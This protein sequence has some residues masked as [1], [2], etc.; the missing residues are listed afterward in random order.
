MMHHRE[1]KK[2]GIPLNMA[3]VPIKAAL[4]DRWLTSSERQ[5]AGKPILRQG[6]TRSM[7]L[8]FMEPQACAPVYYLPKNKAGGMPGVGFHPMHALLQC[9]RT[10][11][12]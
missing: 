1:N 3:G 5:A 8:N 12:W 6:E 10:M 2:S 11:Q 7:P 4:G 9:H